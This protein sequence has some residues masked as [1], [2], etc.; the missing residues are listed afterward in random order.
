MRLPKS[1]RRFVIRV[2]AVGI[3]LSSALLIWSVRK[4]RDEIGSITVL[5]KDD[6]CFIAIGISHWEGGL[7]S[8]PNF[9]W[10]RPVIRGHSVIIQLNRGVWSRADSDFDMPRAFVPVDGVIYEIED[11]PGGTTARKWTGSLFEEV[12]SA[13]ITRT[14][15][16][17]SFVQRSA[18][19]RRVARNTTLHSRRE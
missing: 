2:F 9:P 19:I 8:S 13:R 4:D 18:Q 17:V 7:L 11:F 6:R 16:Q 10:A 3:A 12:A 15:R 14:S 1:C 5:F